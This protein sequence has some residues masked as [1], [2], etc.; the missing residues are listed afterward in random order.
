MAQIDFKAID[1]AALPHL[2]TW[3]QAWIPGGRMEGDE[4]VVRNPNRADSKP[5][6]FKVNVKRGIF[7]DFANPDVDKGVGAVALYAFVFRVKMGEAARE[8]A[9]L[10]GVPHLAPKRA[11]RPKIEDK[12]C[13]IVMPVPHDAPPAPTNVTWK[14]M[15]ESRRWAYMSADKQLLGYVVRVDHDTDVDKETGKLKKDTPQLTCWRM[16]GNGE[17]VW[18]FKHM[19]KPKPLYGLDRLAEKPNAAVLVVEG[20]KAADSA[21][22]LFP[23]LVAMTWP[24]GSSATWQCDVAPLK[25]RAIILWPDADTP[26]IRA[27]IDLR[28]R[29]EKLGI[30]KIRIL[31]PPD[32]V[33]KGW[34]A[35]DA[36]KEGRAPADLMKIL[37]RPHEQGP[38]Y[39]RRELDHSK[40][41]AENQ[42]RADSGATA[43]PPTSAIEQQVVPLGFDEHQVYYYLPR[44]T[45][46]VTKIEGVKHSKASLHPLAP[47]DWFEQCFPAKQGVSWLNAA[48]A[49]ISL[50]KRRGIF[51]P[52]IIRGRGA[53]VENGK[54]V[55]H[56]GNRL[57]IEGKMVPLAEHQSRHVYTRRF[58]CHLSSLDPLP[59]SEAQ[60]VLD[61]VKKLKWKRKIDGT[62]FAGFMAVA[63]ISGMLRW[64]PHVWL[65]AS[66]G[67]GKSWTVANIVVP[68]LGGERRCLHVQG[69]TTEAFIRQSLDG[70]AWPVVFDEAEAKGQRARDRFQNILEL[71]RAASTDNSGAIGKG[72]AA[73][74]AEERV[75]RSSFLLSAIYVNLS[76]SADRSRITQ[77]SLDKAEGQ[78]REEWAALR[79]AA[80]AFT[81]EFADR[82]FMRTIAMFGVL[83]ESIDIF[84]RAIVDTKH[85]DQRFADQ[86]GTLL[87]GAW[88]LMKDMAPTKEQAEKIVGDQDWAEHQEDRGID[89]PF[90]A[91][92]HL[93]GTVIRVENNRSQMT[94]RSVRELAQ[95]AWGDRVDKG[96][97]P[98]E[99]TGAPAAEAAPQRRQAAQHHTEDFPEPSDGAD[100]HSNEESAGQH[101]VLA[102]VTRRGAWDA[103]M[104]HGMRVEP[105]FLVMTPSHPAMSKIFANTEFDL[106]LR[107]IL[108]RLPD[109]ELPEDKVRGKN[110]DGT[111]SHP[112]RVVKIPKKLTLLDF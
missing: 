52:S 49:L 46:I 74:R 91:L 88:I 63:P 93:L 34:D 8:V 39:F 99:E 11:P 90:R 80:S 26:G 32:Q 57:L 15:R 23:S 85:G 55:I 30:Q 77:V 10:A 111:P 81:Q 45:G 44:D 51:R 86:N 66:A 98:D 4:Y 101:A 6:S 79:S 96:R 12:D 17:L 78:S 19:A 36:E 59:S 60:K 14:G 82:L 35:A 42:D 31:T 95:I 16:K 25:G 112:A 75:I 28:G 9:P 50:C 22:R 41:R 47:L 56:L 37:T 29:F 21:Q 97:A 92:E 38:D 3:V 70:D 84:A 62:L 87:A 105:K 53:W 106:A 61:V 76:E 103:L 71:V 40:A 27:A 100:E 69:S 104:R 109:A 13:D 65:T 33:E 58:E 64:R 43:A 67:A 5:G 94:D 107:K 110:Q 7:I 89:D 73:G 48:D 68:L 102:R 20:E 83:K 24:G 2:A 18:R 72:S 1:E 108:R 54:P